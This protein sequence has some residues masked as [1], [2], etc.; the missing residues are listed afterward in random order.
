MRID[1]RRHRLVDGPHAPALE[2]VQRFGH[3]V[4]GKRAHVAGPCLSEELGDVGGSHAFIV[5]A[6]FDA[7][8]AEGREHQQPR[9]EPDEKP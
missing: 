7:L 2:A 3:A 9:D 4:T 1:H 5:Q 8:Q 6:A